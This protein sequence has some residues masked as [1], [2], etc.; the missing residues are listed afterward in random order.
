MA[1]QPQ[2]KRT[3][4]NTPV[5]GISTN[6]LSDM[7]RPTVRICVEGKVGCGKTAILLM[8]RDLLQDKVEVV[9]ADEYTQDEMALIEGGNYDQELKM[10]SPIVILKE[11][12]N[13]TV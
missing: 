7:D 11:Q 3:I 12:I 4:R 6:V 1:D 10:Y 2:G 13:P 9:L 8:I 5:V